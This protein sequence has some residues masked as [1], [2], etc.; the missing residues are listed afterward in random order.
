MKKILILSLFA[1]GLVGCE[2]YTERYN[3]TRGDYGFTYDLDNS[4]SP[5]VDTGYRPLTPFD[6]AAPIVVVVTN[7]PPP[8][9]VYQESPRIG[10]T[11]YSGETPVRAAGGVV[12]QP[13]VE[14]AGAQPGQITEGAGAGAAQ[15]AP[16]AAGVAPGA[17]YYGTGGDVVILPGT[18]APQT[19]TNVTNINS[20]N[21]N[22]NINTNVLG[23]ITNTNVIGGTNTN[24]FATG[25]NAP[26]NE[27]AGT[28]LVTN[29]PVG[30]PPGT[31]FRTNRFGE[32]PTPPPAGGTNRVLFPQI[33]SPGVQGPA[34]RGPESPAVFPQGSRVAP[35]APAPS[36]I[37][38]APVAP[39]QAPAQGVR[40]P[41]VQ[42]GPPASAPQSPPAPAAPPTP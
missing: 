30:E 7:Q 25:T 2:T 37:Q 17:G 39:Q 26:I 6:L 32:P 8:R 36:Q 23:G 13:I 24:A 15:Q 28:Q 33:Q 22:T 42:P 10:E 3:A 27:P 34:P 16:G 41:R 38:T 20:T 1:I 31:Q 14:S 12:A 21:V 5:F 35:T 4:P 40:M 18:N 11:A 19:N 9:I 29:R